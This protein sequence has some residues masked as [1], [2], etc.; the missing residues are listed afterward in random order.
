MSAK[1]MRVPLA[2]IVIFVLGYGPGI[3]SAA[4]IT[5]TSDELDIDADISNFGVTVEASYFNG[6]NDNNVQPGAVQLV[7]PVTVNGVTFTA[8]DFGAGGSLSSLTGLTYNAGEFGHTVVNGLDVD[9]FVDVLLGGSFQA[10]AD[11]NTDGV[12][13]GLDVDPFVAEIVGG[14]VQAVPEPSTL[15]LFALAG[16]AMVFRFSDIL[17]SKGS[18][19]RSVDVR[20]TRC[21]FAKN[22][23]QA[24]RASE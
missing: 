24:R 2:V 23:L 22:S 21:R 16:L 18:G 20:L 17:P 6:N 3:C 4:S 10:E 11:M 5:W 8:T 1:T 9:P 7:D 13:N 19:V 15:A 12:V 14:G